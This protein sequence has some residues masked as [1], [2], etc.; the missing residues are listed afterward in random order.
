MELGV[1]AVG[2]AI[3]DTEGEFRTGF[4]DFKRLGF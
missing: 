3:A 2:E 4:H 1:G